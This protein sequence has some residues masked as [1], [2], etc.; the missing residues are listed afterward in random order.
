VLVLIDRLQETKNLAP[1]VR[2]YLGLAQAVIGDSEKAVITY[3]SLLSEFSQKQDTF[4]YMKVGS[5]K[6]SYLK[7]TTLMTA[8]SSILGE[9]ETD[10]LLAYSIGNSTKDILVVSPQL[11]AISNQIANTK[12]QKVNFTY[13]LNGKKVSKS[14]DKGSSYKLELTPKDLA[15]ITFSDISGSVGLTTVYFAP[16][17]PKTAQVNSSISLGRSY[18]V[19]GKNTNSFSSSDL[20]KITLPF[21]YTS[22]SQDGCYQVSDMLPSGLK[23]VVSAYSYG[24][25]SD[26]YWYPY[27]I[28]GQKVSFCVY[29][30]NNSKV[31]SYYARVISAGDFKAENA[32][33]QSQKAPSIF[34]LSSEGS[35]IIK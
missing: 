27:E 23:P 14:L 1:M 2:I 20:I 9:P 34:N 3:R 25:S 10:S 35:V 22:L 15:D 26:S 12:P 5:D 13:T 19:K 6:D 28:N 31:I 32:L 18:S 16:L 11:F 24:V 4:T 7:A 29:K 30:N 21:S 8:L 33:I 17:D